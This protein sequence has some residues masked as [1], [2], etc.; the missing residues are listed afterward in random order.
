MYGMTQRNVLKEIRIARGISQPKMA[1]ELGCSVQ[2]IK[3][4]EANATLPK[5]AAVLR[6]L[7]ALGTLVNIEVAE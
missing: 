1:E 4:H 2:A 5:N 7:K 6:N 3:L